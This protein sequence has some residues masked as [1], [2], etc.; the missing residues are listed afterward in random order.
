MP[1][2]S[3]TAETLRCSDSARRS[4]IGQAWEATCSG[5]VRAALALAASYQERQ[6]VRDT[7]AELSALSDR[8]LEDIG[9]TRHDIPRVARYGRD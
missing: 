5:I 2:V 6:Q 4:T 3:T 8:M 7:V 9:L 1:T